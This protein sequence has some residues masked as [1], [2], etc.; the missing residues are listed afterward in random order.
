MS[1]VPHELA[2]DFPEHAER[3][4]ALKLS[5]AH[6][7]KLADAYHEVNRAVHRVE[8]RVE[9]ASEAYEEEL[10]KQRLRLKDEIAAILNAKA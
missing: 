4:H 5:D 6:F 10:R 3:I 2:D 7:A 1:H 9:P 8:T